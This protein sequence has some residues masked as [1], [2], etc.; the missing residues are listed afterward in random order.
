MDPRLDDL[1]KT[2]VQQVRLLLMKPVL[3]G[4]RSEP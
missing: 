2:I 4:L 1:I 3:V